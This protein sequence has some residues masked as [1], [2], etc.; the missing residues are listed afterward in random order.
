MA[1]RVIE[2]DAALRDLDEILTHVS[3]TLASPRAAARLLDDYARVV[4]TLESLPESYP[5]VK[6]GTLRAMGYRFAKVG[7]YLVFF[8]AQRKESTVF[9]DRV[10][11][12]RRNWMDFL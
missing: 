11:Y 1:W 12:G 9:I 5:A 4:E 2:A 10:L 6:D 7:S 3:G 8:R